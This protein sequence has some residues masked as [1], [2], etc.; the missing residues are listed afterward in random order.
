MTITNTQFNPFPSSN[1]YTSN[2]YSNNNSGWSGR[3]FTRCS[4]NTP[5]PNAK[6]FSMDNKQYWDNVTVP[7]GEVVP[8]GC[9][10]MMHMMPQF[11]DDLFQCPD[12]TLISKS[13]GKIL[14]DNTKLTDFP[15]RKMTM[16]NFAS[17]YK[18][19]N[20]REIFDFKPNRRNE[21]DNQMSNDDIAYSEM[22]K[23]E[24]EKLKNNMS[25]LQKRLLADLENGFITKKT[26]LID[27]S[28]K[29]QKH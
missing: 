29:L 26:R 17:D 28:Q 16:K 15:S 6:P 20:D 11:N 19:W 22:S 5:V 4:Q 25:D 21:C 3:G 8:M 18:T 1:P 7:N 24:N 9:E 10:N 12:G 13:T 14:R 2:I 27:E 23:R